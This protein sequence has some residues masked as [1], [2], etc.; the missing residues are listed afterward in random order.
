MKS[1]SDA[2]L[3]GILD[4][5]YTP[6][7]D[8][9][10]VAEQMLAGGVDV[11]QL[12]AKGQDETEIESLCARIIPLTESAGVPLI[13]NDYPQLVPSM[14]AQGAHVGQDDFSVA[15]ARWRAGRALAGEVPLPIIGKS[16]HSFEQAVAAEKDGADY[17]GFGPLFATPTKPGRPAIGLEDIARV[18]AAVR[19]PIFCIGGIKLENLDTII[20]AGAR[21]V[22]IVSGLLRA[23]DIAAYARAAKERLIRGP[24]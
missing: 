16:T 2:L 9:E 3:Y 5:G 20:A 23:P 7:A 19:I 11:L 17:I 8:L 14:G 4:L 13:I 10:R 18:H 22:V 12:R 24:R 6:A 1:L 15:D 21:R